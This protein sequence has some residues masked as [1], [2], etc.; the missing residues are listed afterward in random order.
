MTF[1][2][3]L[4]E[5]R[6]GEIIIESVT[7][8]LKR[9]GLIDDRWFSEEARDRGS[10][11]HTLCERFAHGARFD[12]AG[13]HLSSL[14]YVNAFARFVGDFGAYAIDT[15]TI[16]YGEIN[17]H[18]YAGKYDLLAEIH[19][20]RVLIDLKTGVKAKWHH[21]QLAAYAMQAKPHSAMDLYLNPDGTYQASWLTPGQLVDGGRMFKS[22]LM[23]RRS[24]E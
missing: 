17:G 11:V 12:N 4:H 16:I 1:D 6:D 20:K 8:I 19:G 24:Q 21:I 14:Q 9:A 23:T 13:R 22:A 18:R 7:Q 5:Y 2:P 15:E 3:V 10:A